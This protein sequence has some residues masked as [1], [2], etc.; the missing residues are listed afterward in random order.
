MPT[1]SIFGAGATYSNVFLS[2][3]WQKEQSNAKIQQAELP[4]Q[5]QGI[6][7]REGSYSSVLQNVGG[8]QKILGSIPDISS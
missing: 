5:M 1:A 3:V 8:M 7:S 2:S 6:Q 4:M